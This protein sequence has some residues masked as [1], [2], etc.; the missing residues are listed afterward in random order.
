VKLWKFKDFNWTWDEGER[1]WTTQ[2]AVFGPIFVRESRDGTWAIMC[3]DD[4][5]LEFIATGNATDEVAKAAAKQWH[6]ARLSS[7]LV[8]ATEEDVLKAADHFRDV[9]KMVDG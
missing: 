4:V 3:E 5:N 2:D 8:E 6:D 7:S 1:E 9:K